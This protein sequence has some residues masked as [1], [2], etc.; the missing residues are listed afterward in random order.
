VM[1]PKLTTA[2][3][4][5]L[6]LAPVAMAQTTAPEEDQ[7]PLSQ[8]QAEALYADLRGAYE[9]AKFCR[10]IEPSDE[11]RAELAALLNEKTRGQVMP[12]RQLSM[13][14]AAEREVARLHR[15]E[16]CDGPHMS[17]YLGMYDAHL[18]EIF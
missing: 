12:A 10:D 17:E 8:E 18:S 14:D 9:A 15:Q 5:M 13:I 7:L 1:T 16:G 3:L 4:A 2:A 11:D 6:L